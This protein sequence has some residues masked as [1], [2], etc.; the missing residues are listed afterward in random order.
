MH[1]G[2]PLVHLDLK[3]SAISPPHFDTITAPKPQH[4]EDAQLKRIKLSIA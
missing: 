3:N 1:Y 2:L 4:Q